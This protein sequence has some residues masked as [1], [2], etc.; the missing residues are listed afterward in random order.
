MGGLQSLAFEL[1][2]HPTQL[3]YQAALFRGLALRLVRNVLAV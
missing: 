2:L 1:S 3:S